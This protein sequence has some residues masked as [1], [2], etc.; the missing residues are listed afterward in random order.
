M[1]VRICCV[2][3]NI[4]KL[5]ISCPILHRYHPRAPFEAVRPHSKC[6]RAMELIKSLLR[7]GCMAQGRS[8]EELYIQPKPAPLPNAILTIF[9]HKYNREI[10]TCFN[11]TAPHSVAPS[12]QEASLRREPVVAHPADCHTALALRPS[13]QGQSSRGTAT[14]LG[15][16]KGISSACRPDRPQ[17]PPSF[18]SKGTDESFPGAKRQRC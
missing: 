10:S 9:V 15:H 11:E 13:T 12:V 4:S 1:F 16:E 7:T 5:F 18:P 8:W 14:T 2:D 3:G 6:R 17:G